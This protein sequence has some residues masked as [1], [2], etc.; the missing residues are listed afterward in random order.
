MLPVQSASKK[1]PQMKV[2]QWRSSIWRNIWPD[3]FFPDDCHFEFTEATLK[4]N[5]PISSIV[6]C[7]ASILQFA[8]LFVTM[9]LFE[10]FLHGFQISDASVFTTYHSGDIP[11]CHSITQHGQL[12]QQPHIF[13]CRLNSKQTILFFVQNFDGHD[14]ECRLIIKA[15]LTCFSL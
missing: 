3:N 9:L 1:V 11:T 4:F 12:L 2:L 10:N 6:I 14:L 7:L 8:S 5:V 13:S 15:H